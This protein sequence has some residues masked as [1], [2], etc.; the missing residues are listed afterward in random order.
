MAEQTRQE[1]I[2][3]VLETLM[4]MA[5][6]ERDYAHHNLRDY[7][8]EWLNADQ[9]V[10]GARKRLETLKEGERGYISASKALEKAAKTEKYHRVGLEQARYDLAHCETVAYWLHGVLPRVAGR[11]VDGKVDEAA[12]A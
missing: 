12:A 7:M 2:T 10:A 1:I 11:L 9:A 6:R 8:Q 5:M 3:E 4:G